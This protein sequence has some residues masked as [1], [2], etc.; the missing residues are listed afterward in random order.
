MI[1]REGLEN[2]QIGIYVISLVVG[3]LIGLNFERFGTELQWTISPLIAILLYGMFAQIPF[4]KLK[5][6]V[7]NVR[8]MIALL[9]G[10]FVCVPIVVWILTLIFPQSTP[11]LLGI[12]LVLLTPCIDYVILFT[13]LGKGNEKLMLAATPLLFVVQMVLLPLYLWLFIGKEMFNVV[14]IQPF[15]EAFF[16]LIVTPLL[17]AVLTQWWAKKQTLG[18]QA[19]ELTAWLPVPFMALVL[20]VVVASQIDKVY[21]DFTIIIKVVPIY[22]LFLIIMPIVSRLISR[23]FSLDIGAGRALIFSMGTRNSLVVL[24]LALA[25]PEAWRTLAAAVIVTQTMVELIGELIYIKTVPNW[26]L[27]DSK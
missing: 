2:Q 25:L 24:P 7:S 1:T 20:I 14:Q 16:F 6:A 10:N 17:L 27:R 22:V 9:I 3:A 19:L 8:F 13:Q 26:V 23:I 4:L 18:V 11:L 15:L 12:C 21:T 5:E